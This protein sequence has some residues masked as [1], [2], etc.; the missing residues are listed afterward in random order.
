MC[1]GVHYLGCGRV[2]TIVTGV[3]FPYHRW[4]KQPLQKDVGGGDRVAFCADAGED[5]R[6]LIVFL[7]HMVKFEPLEPS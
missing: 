3:P 6:R 2:W 5:I 4:L 1:Q 7:S